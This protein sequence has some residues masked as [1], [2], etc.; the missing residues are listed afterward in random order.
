VSDKQ[1]EL[2]VTSV[3]TISTDFLTDFSGSNPRGETTWT[4]FNCLFENSAESFTFDNAGLSAT[5]D[6]IIYLSPE[7]LIPIY[8][9]FRINKLVTLVR[10]N[11]VVFQ[12]ESIR[13]LEELY[14]DCIAVELKLT[15]ALRG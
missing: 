9:T 13:Y 14:D 6:G 10:L 12:L 7:Q 3:A 4:S 5:F 2:G 8:N 11:G 1:I 15:D